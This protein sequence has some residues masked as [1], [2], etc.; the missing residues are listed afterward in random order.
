MKRPRPFPSDAFAELESRVSRGHFRRYDDPG[1]IPS[2]I[3]RVASFPEPVNFRASVVMSANSSEHPPTIGG[4]A[5]AA[6]SPVMR[7]STLRVDQHGPAEPIHLNRDDVLLFKDRAGK[8]WQLYAHDQPGHYKDLSTDTSL[9]YALE[10]HRWPKETFGTL[11]S[12]RSNGA[13][14][15]FSTGTGGRA[16]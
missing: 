15:D 7:V 9:D 4:V 13:L 10:Q 5:P 16:V 12:L 14:V 11:Q 6:S 2:A 1:G 3:S 8:A